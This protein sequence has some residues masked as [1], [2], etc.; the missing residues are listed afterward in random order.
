MEQGYD[1]GV[2]SGVVMYM[3]LAVLVI[4]G[5][6]A[7]WFGYKVFGAILLAGTIGLLAWVVSGRA[8]M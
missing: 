6:I 3:M 8:W 4:L 7:Y 2:V 5:G 1:M